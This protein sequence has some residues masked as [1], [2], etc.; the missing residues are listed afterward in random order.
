[1]AKVR[2][3]SPTGWEERIHGFLEPDDDKPEQFAAIGR[4]I[5]AFNGVE[6][7]LAWIVRAQIG[8]NKVSRAITGGMRGGD[9][10]AAIKRAAK[11]RSLP[12]DTLIAL[13][14][15][16][17]DIQALRDIR[18][19]VAHRIWAVNGRQMAFTNYHHA[20]FV[21]SADVAIYTIDELNELARYAP[22]LSERA[23]DLF[24]ETITRAGDY[25]LPLRDKPAR[26]KSKDQP[27]SI[28]RAPS[29]R[30]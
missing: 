2:R 10:I 18:D 22:Y 19:Y 24:P 5:T 27:Q 12:D 6:V 25:K 17:Q 29:Y 8:D 9:T 16:A 11:A 28:R 30:L 1:M 15:L 21:E 14:Q 13:D 4:L 23:L 7:I 26:L 3:P 20:R